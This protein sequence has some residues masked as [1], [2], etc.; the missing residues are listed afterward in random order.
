MKEVKEK[1]KTKFWH[2]SANKSELDTKNEDEGYSDP[3][4]E[5]GRV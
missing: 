4:R 1:K 5:E 3:E 2:K